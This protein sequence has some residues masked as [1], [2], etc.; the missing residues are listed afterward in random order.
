MR[1]TPQESKIQMFS[2]KLTT[3][4]FLLALALGL[5]CTDDVASD[6]ESANVTTSPEG[7]AT[8]GDGDGDPETGTDTEADTQSDTETDT[9]DGDGDG[10]QPCEEPLTKL[11]IFLW[12]YNTFYVDKCAGFVSPENPTFADFP[13][14]TDYY[15]EIECLVFWGLIQPLPNQG[16]NPE[17]SLLRA[18]FVRTFIDSFDGSAQCHKEHPNPFWDVTEED[19]YGGPA[20]CGAELGCYPALVD[21]GAFVPQAPVDGCFLYGQVE[22]NGCWQP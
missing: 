7:D 17:F 21:D 18:E 6:G 14:E 13:L 5:G 16:F 20:I 15:A 10:D 22:A 1:L 4:S 19:W 12:L 8:S 3:H 11:E 2:S 9:G